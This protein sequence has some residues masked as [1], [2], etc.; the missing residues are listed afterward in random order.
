MPLRRVSKPMRS[1]LVAALAVVLLG[2]ASAP[3]V[4]A[5]AFKP[6]R[7][8]KSLPP[9]LGISY[10]SM[11]PGATLAWF[12]PVTL[13][14]LAGRKAPLGSHPGSWAFSFDRAVLAIAS[15]GGEKAGPV[16]I[17]FANAR[18]MRVIGDLRLSP[19]GGCASSLTWL[20]P[21]R[22]LVVVATQGQWQLVV[23]D[24]IARR[25]LRRVPL[26]SWT[27]AMGRTRQELVLLLASDGAF[28]PA[29]L[30][31]ADA[32]G[33]VRIASV[34]R[35]VEGTDFAQGSSDSR[36]RTIVPGLA[37]D[38]ESR[39][40]FLVPHSGPVAEIDLATLAVS[41]HELETQSLLGRFMRWLFPSAQAKV[42]EGPEREARWVGDGMIAVSGMDYSIA[43]RSDGAEIATGTPA[44][45][46]LIDTRS[47]T[48]RVL[49]G[50]ASGFAVEPG[51][52]IAQGGRWDSG[53]ERGFGPGLVA[54]SLDGRER[55]R[56]RSGE[57]R[58][59]DPAGSV[60]YVYIAEEEAEVVELATGRVL[61]TIKLG[62]A[63]E[64]WPQLLAAASSN[65]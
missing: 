44:G 2:G 6:T 32:E 42:L 23:V 27:R 18:A 28:A 45:V 11:R 57:Y 24:P 49:N 5:T 53:E 65:W 30:A 38:P 16:G 3:R 21:N 34:D 4:Y 20:R 10:R 19:S 9:V 61:A 60:G 36:S 15:C 26:P 39:R 40:A 1:A 13:R 52:V 43:R 63:Q 22:L 54:F 31:V 33:T 7:A 51:L 46:T 48:S 25:V 41:Y 50:E 59:M 17:R 14:K 35:V 62:S 29:R 12:E 8:A 58:W 47:W 64:S 55:W 37:V 56:L